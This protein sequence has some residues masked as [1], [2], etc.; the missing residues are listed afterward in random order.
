MKKYK[1]RKINAENKKP[2]KDCRMA[3]KNLREQ[4]R[5]LGKNR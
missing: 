5:K 4:G 1:I 3:N 2:C